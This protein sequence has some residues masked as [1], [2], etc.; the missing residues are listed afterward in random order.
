MNPHENRPQAE[1][2][3]FQYKYSAKEQAE[4]KKIRDAY[5][6]APETAA[7]T[8]L[9]RIRRLDAGVVRKGTATALVIGIVGT[10]IMG[11]GMS[12]IMTDLGNIFGVYAHLSLIIGIMI[13]FVG[14]IGVIIAYP[15]YR[16]V[17]AKERRKI[18][19]EILR[20]ADELLKEEP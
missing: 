3:E 18:A 11:L 15:L 19:P 13:G 20:L 14:M 7:L 17:T 12:L 16:F 10:L 2:I 4:L 8:G 6:T 9:A 1:G 5:T